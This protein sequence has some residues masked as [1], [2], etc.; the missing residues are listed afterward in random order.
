MNKISLF[1]L[2]IISFLYGACKPYCSG[3][4]LSVSVGYASPGDTLSIYTD[5]TLIVSKLFQHDLLSSI[6]DKRNKVTE[7]CATKDSLLINISYN[8]KDSSKHISAKDTSFYIH[9]KELKGFTVG[10]SIRHEIH[11][12]LDKVKGGYGVYEPDM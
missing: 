11:V 3:I 10:L 4:Q 5:S 6:R 1:F 7:I 8:S 9:P 12:Y 2:I